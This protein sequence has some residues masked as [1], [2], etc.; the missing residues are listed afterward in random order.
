[1]TAVA[2]GGDVVQLGELRL[3]LDQDPVFAVVRRA[4]VPARE[5]GAAAVDVEPALL[6]VEQQMFDGDAVGVIQFHQRGDGKRVRV[7]QRHVLVGVAR[8]GPGE[9]LIVADADDRRNQ[10]GIEQ[11]VVAPVGIERLIGP[12]AVNA[13]HVVRVRLRPIVELARVAVVARGRS[14]LLVVDGLVGDEEI[15]ARLRHGEALRA[16]L[17]CRRV[18]PRRTDQRHLHAE[19]VGAEVDAVVL[20]NPG[21]DAAVVGHGHDV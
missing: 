13:Q 12:Q 16:S 7:G 19:A 20:G 21:I 1:M 3:V 8:A 11:Q 14:V 18:A 5:P 2:R 9:A 17:E 4:E 6:I 10:R 15:V